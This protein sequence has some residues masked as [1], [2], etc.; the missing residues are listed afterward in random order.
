MV[1]IGWVVIFQ[2]GNVWCRTKSTK[3][4]LQHKHGRVTVFLFC[5][6]CNPQ[7]IKLGVNISLLCYG[8][9]IWVREH[10]HGYRVAKAKVFEVETKS[11]KKKLRKTTTHRAIA[12]TLLENSFRVVEQK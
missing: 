7:S 5:N 2:L 9:R 4:R 3:S 12:N 6:A 11:R 1:L 10:K 8:A